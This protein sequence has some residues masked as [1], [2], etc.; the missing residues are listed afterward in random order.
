M[1]RRRRR[2]YVG[3]RKHLPNV[4]KIRPPRMCDVPCCWF[5]GGDPAR[6]LQPMREDVARALTHSPGS[7]A[8]RRRH[9]ND[10]RSLNTPCSTKQPGITVASWLSHQCTVWT[11][12]VGP[13]AGKF[14]REWSH[15]YCPDGE[16]VLHA[17]RSNG[18]YH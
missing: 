3:G 11:I 14:K 1:L 2:T 13:L 6:L 5:G 17:Q 8:D 9:A 15:E 16:C 4:S 10:A 18:W 7:F 12:F